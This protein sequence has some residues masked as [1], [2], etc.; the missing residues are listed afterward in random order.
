[1]RSSA[2]RTAARYLHLR[3]IRRT[4]LG[5]CP[6]CEDPVF[7]DEKTVWRLLGGSPVRVHTGCTTGVQ[8]EENHGTR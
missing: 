5:T 3:L 8:Q 6:V 1:M 2:A 4:E 7:A